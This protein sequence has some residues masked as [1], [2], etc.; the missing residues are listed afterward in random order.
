MNK[1]VCLLLLALL[2]LPLVGICEA[3]FFP[4]P[5]S[6][7]HVYIRADGS[8]EPDS[9]P[10]ERD[11]DTYTFTGDLHNCTLVIQRDKVVVDGAKYV[12]LGTGSGQGLVLKNLSGVTVQNLVLR[13]LRQGVEFTSASNCTLSEVT[14]TETELGVYMYASSGNVIENSRIKANSG[15]GIVMLDGCNHNS[16]LDNQITNNGNGGVVLQAPNLV[17]NQSACDHNRIVGNNIT[18]NTAYNLWLSSSAD[19]LIQ[20]NTIGSSQWGI[21]LHGATCKNN[22]ILL[23]RILVCVYG[24]ILAG[25]TSNNTIA[26]NT[27]IW[28]AV[29]ADI[30]LS[31]DNLFYNNNFVYNYQHVDNHHKETSDFESSASPQKNLWDHGAANGGNYWGD[32]TG[33]DEDS[34]GYI[35]EPYVID[36]NNVD[37]YPLVQTFGEVEGYTSP[38]PAPT[39][40]PTA[41]PSP[42]ESTAT[43]NPPS[44]PTFPIETVFALI[45]VIGV[46]A[47][48]TV[49]VLKKRKPPTDS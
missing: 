42:T 16:L 2:L 33:A 28:D 48:A 24:V 20:R 29:G 44:D 36:E 12:L 18:E 45:A 9:V 26:K 21:Q 38:T 11:G 30:P 40:S 41:S 14:V 27:F 1:A 13:N 17:L 49:F 46:V 19:C 23:N 25:Q 8:L 6:L 35:D 10:I 22:S 37:N 32:F 47:L 34:D 3:N 4:P 39:Q 5:A 7:Q 31:E 15:D 43:P